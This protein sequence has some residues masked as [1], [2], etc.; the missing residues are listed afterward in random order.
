MLRPFQH[1]RLEH[2][3]AQANDVGDVRRE[4]AQGAGFGVG[5]PVALPVRVALEE[6]ARPGELPGKIGEDELRVGAPLM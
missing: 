3:A 1:V 6:L 4:L 5:L 2:R